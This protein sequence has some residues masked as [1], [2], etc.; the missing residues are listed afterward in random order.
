MIPKI[1]HYCWFGQGPKPELAVKCIE[2]WKKYCPDYEIIEWNEANFDIH[3]NLYV[4]QAYEHRKYAFV[5][6][7]VRLYAMYNQGGVYMDTDVEVL[8]SLDEFLHHSA[9]S[10]FENSTQ[11]PTGL[12]ASEKN[13]PLFGE[14]L[15]FYD[16]AKFIND[17]SSLNIVTN[18]ETITNALLLKGF[19][20]N[21]KYQVVEGF[22]LYPQN[23]FCPDHKKLDNKKYMENAATIHFF[24]GSW[25]SQEAK[26]REGKWW[27]KLIIIPL[28]KAS[29]IIED[30]GGKP[31]KK[32]KNKLWGTKIKEKDSYEN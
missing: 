7:Y 20:P 21:G 25:K 29:H 16:T 28:S 15:K 26:E 27:W 6:D 11:I 24:A 3:S 31:Y 4:E 5:T 19:I 32:L 13:F 9:V 10:G 30:I 1:I 17:D 8:K 23:V 12:M 14:L 18:V 22:A 2:S